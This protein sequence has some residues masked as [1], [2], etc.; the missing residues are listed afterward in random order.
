MDD[1]NGYVILAGVCLIFG[2]LFWAVSNALWPH[3]R[4]S[5]RRGRKQ[6]AN[7]RL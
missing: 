5:M 7:H 6:R 1:L 4:R 3:L 2:T